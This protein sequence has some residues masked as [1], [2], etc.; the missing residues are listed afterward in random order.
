ML[1][2]VSF[3]LSQL[4]VFLEFVNNNSFAATYITIRN[5]YLHSLHNVKII[6]AIH[7]A[8]H[9]VQYTQ[10]ALVLNFLDV[11]G[12]EVESLVVEGR[13][14]PVLGSVLGHQVDRLPGLGLGHLDLLS[15][16]DLDKPHAPGLL[17][18][19]VLVGDVDDLLHLL[20]RNGLRSRLRLGDVSHLLPRIL[21]DAPDCLLFTLDSRL[22]VSFSMLGQIG[23]VCELLAT[24]FAQIRSLTGVKSHVFGQS[25]SF[26]ESLLAD[27]TGV[28]LLSLVSPQMGLERVLVE[29]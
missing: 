5:K 29:E 15:L 22:F 4:Y 28:R 24:F 19:A 26:S 14:D 3:Y 21:H 1:F 6:N 16:G 7:I 17:G 20:G 11:L 18:L 13:H 27:L 8:T 10:Q 12:G 9:T 2:C 25:P 23:A